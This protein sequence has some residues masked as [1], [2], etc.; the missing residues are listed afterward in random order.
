MSTLRLC[1]AAALVLLASCAA[2][3]RS[4]HPAPMDGSG[5]EDAIRLTSGDVVRGRIVEETSRQVVIER[6]H[7]V[8]TY[9][10]AAVF[11]IDYSKERW[12]ER[13]QA[14][15]PS[16]PPAAS[17]RPST[18]WLPRADPREPVQQTEVLFYDT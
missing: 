17:V 1:S 11:S 2:P 8:S 15:A 13:R 16:D 12:Q 4:P 18:T 14:L 9:P 3:A 7:V 6:E 10:R 5:T